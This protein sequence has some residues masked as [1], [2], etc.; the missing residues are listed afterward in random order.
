MY[1]SGGTRWTILYYY[2]FFFPTI[3]SSRNDLHYRKKKSFP[4]SNTQNIDSN[5]KLP[6]EKFLY[7]EAL[8]IWSENLIYCCI[9][10]TTIRLNQLESL[11]KYWGNFTG[12][13]Q[14]ITVIFFMSFANLWWTQLLHWGGN[15]LS[16]ENESF[17]TVKS[18]LITLYNLFTYIPI[19]FS[20]RRCLN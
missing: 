17:P 14:L 2:W 16:S 15:T 19:L 1:D 3:R 11:S 20:I 6:E 9:S 18:I 7:I 8:L 12:H 13:N 5:D 4:L 10:C